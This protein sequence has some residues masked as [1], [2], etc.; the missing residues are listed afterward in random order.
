M[1][2]Q[3]LVDRNVRFGFDRRALG[4]ETST[5]GYALP[6]DHSHGVDDAGSAGNNRQAT[7]NAAGVD[8]GVDYHSAKPGFS[9]RHNAPRRPIFRVHRVSLPYLHT[10]G[11]AASCPAG[12][13]GPSHC[14][15]KL[16]A[17]LPRR[18]LADGRSWQLAL[19]RIFSLGHRGRW[20]AD[21]VEVALETRT[22]GRRW[23]SGLFA[24]IMASNAEFSRSRPKPQL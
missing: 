6:V 14:G 9:Q 10:A 8:A 17:N 11:K 24:S 12:F 1:S 21:S 19:W 23:K 5:G 15:R 18:P 20:I 16:F 4:T 2:R 22:P 13:V 3:S 7:S